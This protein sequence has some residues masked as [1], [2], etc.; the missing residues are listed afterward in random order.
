MSATQDHPGRVE[1]YSIEPLERSIEHEARSRRTVSFLGEVD[2]TQVEV[3]RSKSIASRKPSYTA[4]VVKAVALALR[5][6]PYANRRVCRPGLW[7]FGSS[8]LQAFTRRD[9]AFERFAPGAG[10]TAPSGIIRDADGDLLESIDTTIEASGKPFVGSD[11]RS[12][13]ANGSTPRNA[14]APGPWV[15]YRGGAAL[16]SSTDEPGVDAVLATGPYAIGVTFGRVKLRPVVVGHATVA[17]P[18]IFLGANFDR[19]VVTE[20]QAARFFGRIVEVLEKAEAELRAFVMLEAP[21]TRIDF[22]TVNE[23]RTTL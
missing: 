7:P 10:R 19:R 16:V 23:S 12:P 21:P 22:P 20:A 13:G 4:F 11:P 1:G 9:V 6:L 14:S 15:K 3:M 2:L 8:K 5:E 17:R 18:S